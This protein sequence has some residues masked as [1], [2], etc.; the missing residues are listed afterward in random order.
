MYHFYCLFI[1]RALYDEL[2]AAYPGRAVPEPPPK[3]LPLA[4]TRCLLGS[5]GGRFEILG[6]IRNFESRIAYPGRA[7]PEPPP[8]L[9][10][11]AN[12]RLFS[13]GVD[14]G[15]VSES[16]GSFRYFKGRIEVLKVV[17]CRWP[18]PGSSLLRGRFEIG[19]SIQNF[20]DQSSAAGQH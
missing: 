13:F 18:T 1:V 4:N 7:V 14:W 5:I 2:R 3:L 19:G 15:V 11:L 16:R 6:S 10:P 20:E 17:R 9:L 12:T 8:K